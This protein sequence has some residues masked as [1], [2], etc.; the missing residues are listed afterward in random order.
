MGWGDDMAVGPGGSAV[1]GIDEHYFGAQAKHRN[2]LQVHTLVPTQNERSA[3]RRN[4][5]GRE[6]VGTKGQLGD[7]LDVRPVGRVRLTSPLDRLSDRV[8]VAV[9]LVAAGVVA[10]LDDLELVPGRLEVVRG[11]NKGERGTVLEPEWDPPRP[12]ASRIRIYISPSRPGWEGLSDSYGNE[13]LRAVTV[14]ERL[15]D[16]T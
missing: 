1:L 5:R 10:V 4:G 14:I 12:W 8:A 7:R 15:A 13:W 3:V 9:G 2:A 16:L 6:R 11:P